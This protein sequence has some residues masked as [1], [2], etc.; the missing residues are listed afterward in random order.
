MDDMME[1]VYWVCNVCQSI[2]DQS[3]SQ[4]TTPLPST[5][6]RTH[7]HTD[8]IP[9]SQGKLTHQAIQL[10][11]NLIL[12]LAFFAMGLEVTLGFPSSMI[13]GPLIN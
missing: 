10:H 7:T 6:V 12:I 5:N 1:Y 2:I 8:K 9:T 13:H 3:S 11:T 4:L